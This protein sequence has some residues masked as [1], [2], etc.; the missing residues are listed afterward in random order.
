MTVA[1]GV[2]VTTAFMIEEECVGEVEVV[3][4][5]NNVVIVAAVNLCD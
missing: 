3:H 1:I 4:S 2:I 5:L